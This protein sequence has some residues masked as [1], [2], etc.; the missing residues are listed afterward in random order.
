MTAPR[1]LVAAEREGVIPF[2]GYETW[3]RITGEL[4]PDRTPLVTLH[5]GP[6][7]THDYLLTLADL[8]ERT[9]RAVIHD[10]QPGTSHLPHVEERDNFMTLLAGFLAAV[11]ER[12][13]R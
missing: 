7:C 8:A 4:R 5:G 11:D 6:G 2:G 1:A 13:A 9:A 12:V 10:D 3:Y